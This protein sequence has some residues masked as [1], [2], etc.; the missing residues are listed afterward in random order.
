M[1][2]AARPQELGVNHR[3]LREI[4]SPLTRRLPQWSRAL[5]GHPDQAFAQFILEGI[6]HGFR[7]GF[8]H[9]STLVSATRNMP[10]AREHPDVITA[11]IEAEVL[12]GRMLGP[13]SLDRFPDAHWNRMGVVPKGHT[14]GR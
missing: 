3:E 4:S 1:L 6:E 7:I 12:E 2:D 13:F 10:S 8:D 11:Y 14:S 5:V 9:A